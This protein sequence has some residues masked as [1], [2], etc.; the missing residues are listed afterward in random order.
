MKLTYRADIDGIRAIAVLAVIFYHADLKLFS[1][2]YVGVDVFFVISGYLITSILLKE[3]D[4]NEF[5]LARFY[6]RRIRRIFPALFAFMAATL[7]ISSVFFDANEFQEFGK[8]LIATTLFSSNILFWTQSGYFEGPSELK[9][10]LHT[11]SLAVEEQ[12]YILFPLLLA[13]L[14]RYVRPK[15]APAL[16]GIAL[17]S[18]AINIY[19]LNH[20]PSG[21]FYLAHMRVW[22]LLMGSILAT[23]IIPVKATLHVR[24]LL[25]LIGLGMIL[26]P[27]FL[28]TNDTPF[29]GATAFIPTFGTALII[30]S[31]DESKTFIGRILGFWPLVFIGQISYSLY[32]WHWPLIVFARY[33]AIIELKAQETAGVL[34]AIFILSSLSWRFIETPFRKK[35]FLKG[36]WIFAFAATTMVLTLSVGSAIYL[37]G[38]FPG[39]FSSKQAD[40]GQNTDTQWKNWGNCDLDANN[41]SS[42]LELCA[43]GADANTPVFLLWGD[44]HARALATSIQT[45]ASQA[46]ITGVTAYTSGCAPLLG[47]DRQGQKPCGE[48]NTAIINYIQSRPNLKT[49]ILVSRWAL[50]AE[51]TR[52]KTEEGKSVILVNALT[53]STQ[54]DT[55]E[56]LFK[57]GLEQTVNKLLEMGRKVVIV[58]QVPEIGYDVPSAFSIAQRTGRDLNKIIAPSLGEYLDRNLIVA[59]AVESLAAKGNVQIV[60]PPQA[61][62]T[63]GNCLVVSEGHPLYRDDDHLS[64]FGARYISYL[65]DPIFENLPNE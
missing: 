11:W 13:L 41:L 14:A 4:G 48:F 28:Y 59:S 12:F 1:G 30:Y 25:G 53:G 55:N 51:G 24:N 39:R 42:P 64:T 8:S 2:G 15:L 44:S 40:T 31:G 10:L 46:E 18:F 63:G 47:I 20:D 19:G 16:A 23:R 22:E 34:L 7:V 52:Y 32:L 36:Q 35:T 60:Y 5:S 33:Y 17:T 6:E 58:T 9:P 57:L 49:V 26:A 61:L 27:V 62:C 21:A 45:S 38:G 29:P 56:T 3:L 65:F 37:K 50:S 43:I 54:T